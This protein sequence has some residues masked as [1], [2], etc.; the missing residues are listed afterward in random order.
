MS[1]TS[2]MEKGSLNYTHAHPRIRL[3][4]L[5]APTPVAFTVQKCAPPR[6]HRLGRRLQFGAAVRCAY[7]GARIFRFVPALSARFC[8]CFPVW[9]VT[10][11][12]DNP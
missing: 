2:V 4:T 12:P 9:C 8:Y 11:R 10:R 5:T 6:R 7:S 3:V 1:V